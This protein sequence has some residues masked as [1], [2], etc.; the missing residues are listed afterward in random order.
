MPRPIRL[1][2]RPPSSTRRHNVWYRSGIRFG[3]RGSDGNTLNSHSIQGEANPCC[4]LQDG[5][6]SYQRE[7]SVRFSLGLSASQF[8]DALFI[9]HG[10][11][12]SH[13]LCVVTTHQQRTGEVV[14]TLGDQFDSEPVSASSLYFQHG[15]CQFTCRSARHPVSTPTSPSFDASNTNKQ[16]FLK[17]LPMNL[18]HM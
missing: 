12:S 15:A 7:P 16:L 14:R 13:S 6:T 5:A 1:T 10:T 8:Q 3:R 2:N 4:F 18:I 17:I 11:Y 9:S